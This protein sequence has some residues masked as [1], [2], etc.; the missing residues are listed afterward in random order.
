MDFRVGFGYDSHRLEAGLKLRLGGVDI[1]SEKGCVAHSDGDAL[2]HALCDALFGAAGLE[3]IGTHF[4]DNDLNFKGIDSTI[5]LART[6]DILHEEGWK[7]N[8]TD[9]TIILERPKLADYKPLIKNKLAEI[10]RIAP[11]A[12]SVKAK[13]NEKMGFLGR[14][15]G[16]AA[17]AAVTLI[18]ET[19]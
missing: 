16:V 2:I 13:T 10:L 17:L 4:P 1:E 11:A 15:E 5:L 18:R 7:I 8:N 19:E 12:V 14:G 9:L 6:V 3:D